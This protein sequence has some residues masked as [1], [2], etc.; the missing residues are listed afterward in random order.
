M[1]AIYHVRAGIY[2]DFEVTSLRRAREIIR[3]RANLG[4]PIHA[5][6]V[7]AG[8]DREWYC[9]RTRADLVRD[10]ND[11]SHAIAVITRVSE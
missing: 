7:D 11:G 2:G 10:A 4:R 8:N 6:E 1:K 9:Y 5:V 3:A